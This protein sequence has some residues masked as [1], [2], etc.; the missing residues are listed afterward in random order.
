MQSL[1]LSTVKIEPEAKKQAEAEYGK[2][3]MLVERQLSRSGYSEIR[4]GDLF[5]D[6]I[7]KK[8]TFGFSTTNIY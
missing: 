2:L 5:A 3:K 1:C 4:L 6:L 8:S 7:P